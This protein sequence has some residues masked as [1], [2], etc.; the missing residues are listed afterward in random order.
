MAG[1]RVQRVAEQVKEEIGEIIRRRYPLHEYGMITV[2]E[3]RMGADLR[4]ARI[5][6]S[7]FGS[8]EKKQ[9]TKKMLDADMPEIRMELAA[10]IRL[11]F[12]PELLFSMDDSL[13]HAMNVAKILKQIEEDRSKSGIGPETSA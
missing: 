12:V 4:N 2:T 13:D 11:R 5:F 8:E 7:I 9:K 3:V 10:R 6:I 1:I